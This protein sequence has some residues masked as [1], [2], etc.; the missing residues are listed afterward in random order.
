M[1][2]NTNRRASHYNIS[3]GSEHLGVTRRANAVLQANTVLPHARTRL[4]EIFEFQ[5]LWLHCNAL[6]GYQSNDVQNRHLINVG[7]WVCTYG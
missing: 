3:G 6:V 4:L 2:A 1:F 5:G 7:N